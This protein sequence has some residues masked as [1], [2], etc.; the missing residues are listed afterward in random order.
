M[1]T[2]G[3]V[4]KVPYALKCSPI[5]LHGK[6]QGFMDHYRKSAMT[7]ASGKPQALED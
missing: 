1:D 6:R 5:K 4:D 3:S 2:L 7:L